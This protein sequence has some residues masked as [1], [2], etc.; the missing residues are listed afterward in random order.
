MTATFE[1]TYWH[2]YY[3]ASFPVLGPTPADVA[4]ELE[5]LV[6]VGVAYFPLAF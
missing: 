2:R 5:T 1:P 6:D 3:K 4:R